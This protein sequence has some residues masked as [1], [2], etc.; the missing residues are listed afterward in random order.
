MQIDQ[1]KWRRVQQMLERKDEEITALQREVVD[2][3]RLQDKI[4][5]KYQAKP[6]SAAVIASLQSQLTASKQ[7]IVCNTVLL[8]SVFMLLQAEREAE[9]KTL[10]KTI[11]Q[12]DKAINEL[13]TTLQQHKLRPQSI[14]QDVIALKTRNRELEEITVKDRASIAALKEKILRLQRSVVCD[15][16][17]ARKWLI[18]SQNTRQRDDE[19]VEDILS[20]KLAARER[21]LEDKQRLID[22][23]EKRIEVLTRNRANPRPESPAAGEV[24]EIL[25]TAQADSNKDTQLRLS[26]A[27]PRVTTY[28]RATPRKQTEQTSTTPRARSPGRVAAKPIKKISPTDHSGPVGGERRKSAA[29]VT[30]RSTLL[31]QRIE[32]T[33]S[34]AKL[35][36]M[37]GEYKQYDRCVLLRDVLTL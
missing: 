33:D 11:R 6:D 15:A 20:R 25:E 9:I 12:K 37:L 14:E 29:P 17:T 24:P 18:F 22:A 16:T 10:Q 32:N 21:T 8:V 36:Q 2:Q 26:K 31:L 3:K 34:A 35:Q 13:D 4:R 7:K 27:R 19:S 28:T 5:R 1:E 23:L 30:R